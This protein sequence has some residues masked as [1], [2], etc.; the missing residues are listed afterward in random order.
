M[1]NIS[2]TFENGWNGIL[3]A[4]VGLVHLWN[5]PDAIFYNSHSDFNEDTIVWFSI[6][7]NRVQ[8]WNSSFLFPFIVLYDSKCFL[9]RFKLMFQQS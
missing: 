3:D 4:L 1:C 6:S 7:S 2:G 9:F 5:D 8:R